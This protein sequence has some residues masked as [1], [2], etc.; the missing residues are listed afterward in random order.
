MTIGLEICRARE[1]LL[2]DQAWLIVE[3]LALSKQGD[4]SISTLIQEARAL[5][6]AVNALNGDWERITGADEAPGIGD[7]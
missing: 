4:H 3:G 6:S 2:V 1:R 5:I 7:S